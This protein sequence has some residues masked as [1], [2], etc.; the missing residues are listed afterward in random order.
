MPPVLRRLMRHAE[1]ATTMKYYV[2]MDAD[3]VADELWGR[4]WDQGNIRGDS[5]PKQAKKPETAPA[6]VS[7]EAVDNKALSSGG[8]GARTRNPITG[9]PHFQFRR[10]LQYTASSVA[11]SAYKSAV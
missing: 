2:T 9:A 6:D 3:A 7:T 11:I 5:R 1:I 8:H 4:D 10:W